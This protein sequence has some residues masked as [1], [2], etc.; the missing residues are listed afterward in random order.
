[1]NKIIKKPFM[2]KSLSGESKMPRIRLEEQS[3]YEFEY[4]ITIGTRDLNYAGHLGNDAL[5]SLIQEARVSLFQELGYKELDLGDGKTGI[6]IGDLV[7]NF[8]A[9]GFMFDE[10]VIQSQIREVTEKSMRL[11]HRVV[12]KNDR[13]LLALVETGLI[14]YDYDNRKITSF[15]DKFLKRLEKIQ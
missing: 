9:E 12:K 8:K 7:I 15:P 14:V 13:T 4:E 1:M 11:F 5:V 6:I 2:L 10:L 3:V